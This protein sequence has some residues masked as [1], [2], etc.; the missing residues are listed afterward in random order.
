[1][2][3]YSDSSGF[4]CGLCQQMP[5]L[6]DINESS[7]INESTNA[8]NTRYSI[9]KRKVPLPPV[10]TNY[11]PQN[12]RESYYGPKT[13]F[14][15]RDAPLETTVTQLLQVRIFV[16][17]KFD[18]KIVRSKVT[19]EVPSHF[20]LGYILEAVED[21]IQDLDGVQIYYTTGSTR[22]RNHLI[23]I[24]ITPNDGRAFDS[25]RNNRGVVNFV[26]AAKGVRVLGDKMNRRIA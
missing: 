9:H 17:E 16:L 7:E 2:S 19:C 24:T 18:R 22:K 5:S 14:K 13:S 3:Q 15:N 1:M 26:I 21:K 4:L 11:T 23:P 8:L 10:T 6:A 12:A 20:K 25:I